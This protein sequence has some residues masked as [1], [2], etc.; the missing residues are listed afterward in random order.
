MDADTRLWYRTVLTRL[1]YF[2]EECQILLKELTFHRS[3]MHNCTATTHMGILRWLRIVREEY[4][5]SREEVTRAQKLLDSQRARGYPEGTRN[6][7]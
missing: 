7:F 4:L 5:D 1:I 6:Q 3:L 2:R